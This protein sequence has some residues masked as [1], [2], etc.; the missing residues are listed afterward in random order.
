MATIN[1]VLG[2][3]ETEDL[4]FTLMHEHIIVTSWAMRRCF[5]GYVDEEKLMLDAVREVSSARDRGVRTMVDL[6]AINLG[7]DI[8]V[9]RDVAEKTGMQL[10]AATGFYWTEEPWMDAWEAEA[11]A[12]YLIREISDGIEGTASRAGLRRTAPPL[13]TLTVEREGDSAAHL[14]HAVL[15]EGREPA[16][17]A[18]L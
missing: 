16:A 9:I 6:T 2:P 13:V 8:H 3:I 12:E 4:G 11:L 7:R 17:E 18:G 5:P 15:R 10:I 1:G 14:G